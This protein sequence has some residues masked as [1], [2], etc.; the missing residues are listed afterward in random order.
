MIWK[1]FL[2][3]SAH[4]TINRK[5]QTPRIA[6]PINLLILHLFPTAC[7]YKLLQRGIFYQT[8]TKMAAG[9]VNFCGLP[10]PP[11]SPVGLSEIAVD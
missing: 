6:I 11:G 3:K 10:E 5:S 8:L 2:H 4:V 1:R 9:L 7:V